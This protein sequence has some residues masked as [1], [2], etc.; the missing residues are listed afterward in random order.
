MTINFFDWN[1]TDNATK[2][3][4]F[5]RAQTDL[6]HYIDQI[7]PIVEDVRKR[8]DAALAH[9]EDKFNNVTLDPTALKVS[10]DELDAAEG[11]V[12]DD[13]KDTL[14]ACVGNVRTHYK[15][16]KRHFSSWFTETQPGVVTGEIA[17]PIESVGLYV[18]GAKNTFPSTVY[19]LGVPA[20]VAGVP[21]V[22]MITQAMPDGRINPVTLYTAKLSG[23]ENIYKI[24]GAHGIAALGF[25]TQTVPAVGKILGPGSM[26]ALAARLILP[27]YGVMVDPGFPAGPSESI[28]LCDG[29]ANPHNTVLDMINEAEHGDDSCGILVTHDKE[30]ADYVREHLPKEIESLPEP[31]RGYCQT[32]MC[33]Y[34]GIIVTDSIDESIQFVNDYAPEHVLVKVDSPEDV[35]PRIHN[36]AAILVGEWTPNTLANFSL[37]SNHS[38]PTGGAASIYSG[39][40]LLE[41]MKFAQYG[42]V[43][44]QAAFEAVGKPA[45]HMARIEGFPGHENAVT[46]RTNNNRGGKPFN[47]S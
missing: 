4:I 12:D 42:S 36:A 41:F 9:Y 15:A 20:S 23:I 8:G 11:Q 43:Q 25:G 37:G 7:R 13:I 17:S 31:Q 18:P 47:P 33:S 14:Q 40:S 21:N 28:V 27:A 10:Q 38:L 26:Y 34:G 2:Q 29:S 6:A 16:A 22:S 32:N 5:A 3:K 46:K 39:A 45:A 1:S 19:M 30:L 24:S 44:N 35:V